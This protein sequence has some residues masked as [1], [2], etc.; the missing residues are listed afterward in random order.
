MAISRSSVLT[1]YVVGAR[2]RALAGV[3]LM[4]GV[5]LLMGFRSSASPLAWLGT[6]GIVLLVALALTWPAVA[7]GLLAKSVAGTTPFVL[8]AQMLPFLSSAFVPTGSMSAAVRW[9]AQYEPFTPVTDSLRGLL[10]GTPIGHEW[11]AA[12]AWCV[13]LALGGY[14]WARSLFKRGP[15]R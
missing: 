7:V 12:L 8:I 9:F 3:T 1:G 4:I 6:I 11:I 5:A 13:G 15:N 10:L 2:L 14:L